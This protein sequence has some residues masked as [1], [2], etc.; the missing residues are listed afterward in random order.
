M[1]ESGT[2]GRKFF[3]QLVGLSWS[4]PGV[5]DI[6][7]P[8]PGRLLGGQ[9]ACVERPDS[10]PLVIV[11]ELDP[12]NRR[13]WYIV[14]DGLDLKHGPLTRIPLRHWIHA[15]FHS[16]FEPAAAGARR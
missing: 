15:G 13:A 8:A 1:S 2:S 14:L 5:T 6:Y 12:V 10:R 9:P 11:Q 3:D 4:D 7:Q 16:C